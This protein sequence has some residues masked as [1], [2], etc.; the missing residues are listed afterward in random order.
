MK[1]SSRLARSI[2]G[3]AAR[4]V[5]RAQRSDWREEWL[6]ELEVLEAERSPPAT[7]A[8]LPG[9]IAFALGS[10]PHALWTRSEE[11]TMGGML[12][13]LRFATRVRH[14][15]P[16]GRRPVKVPVIPNYKAV[17]NLIPL[18]VALACVSILSAW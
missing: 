8:G 1:R 17:I 16:D 14:C 10:L 15:D 4:I 11:W 5:P 7:A 6:C 9:P 13:D 18:V 3:A 2:I 12:Q